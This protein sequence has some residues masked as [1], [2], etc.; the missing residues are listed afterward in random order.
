MRILVR[1][2][3]Y[4]RA[5]NLEDIMEDNEHITECIVCGEIKSACCGEDPEG[6]TCVDCCGPHTPFNPNLEDTKID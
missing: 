1:T 2:S 3:L 4:L 6:Y 5:Q